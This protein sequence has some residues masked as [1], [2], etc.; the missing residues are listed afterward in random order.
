MNLK[1]EHV[2]LLTN[3][4]QLQKLFSVKK[5]AEV[6]GISE[7]TWSN[8][9]KE[10]WKLFSFDDFALIASYCKVDF[11]TLVSGTLTMR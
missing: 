8:R 6:I 9:M 7:R 11:E 2:R 5:L 4:Q 1:K 3:L 10:P